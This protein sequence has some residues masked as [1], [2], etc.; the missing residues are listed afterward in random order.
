M[1]WVSQGCRAEFQYLGGNNNG[2]WGNQNN[3]S[4]T[5][6]SFNGQYKTCAWDRNRGTPRLIERI[7]GRCTERNDWG[8]DKNR[9]LW[10]A[11]SCSA[12]FGIR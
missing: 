11:N 12:R 4:V 6:T 3:Y 5:C 7:S 1:I 8:F 10:V 9:G 2:N